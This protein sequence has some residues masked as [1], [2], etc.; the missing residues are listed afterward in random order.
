MHLP[1]ERARRVDDLQFTFLGGLPNDRRD[2]VRA[3]HQ[4]TSARHFVHV[5]D[6]H[7]AFVLES[8]YDVPIVNDLVKYIQRR[9]EHGDRPIQGID[10]HVHAG[11]KASRADEQNSHGETVSDS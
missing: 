10:C 4:V 2:A 11:A 5:I 9:A 7:H 1:H 6:E 8:L 3:V